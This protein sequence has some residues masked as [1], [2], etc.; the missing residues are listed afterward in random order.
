MEL[1]NPKVP[2]KTVVPIMANGE[3]KVQV[4]LPPPEISKVEKL[5]PVLLVVVA[6]GEVSPLRSSTILFVEDPPRLN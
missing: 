1:D 2:P 4:R 6:L 5:T 3:F